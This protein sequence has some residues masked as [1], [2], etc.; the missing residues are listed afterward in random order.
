MKGSFQTIASSSL[1][2]TGTRVLLKALGAVATFL[3]LRQLSMAH[4][5]LVSLALGVSGPV[6]ALSGLG[7]DDLLLAMGA[8]ARGEK[9]F[10]AFLPLFTGFTYV[11]FTLT[12]L[13]I[14]SSFW[15][16]RW[17]TVDQQALI[18]E[19]MVPLLIWVALVALRGHLDAALQMLERFRDYAKMGVVEQVIRVS[20]VIGL[21]LMQTISVSTVIWS[22]VIAKGIST[23]FL[24]PVVREVIAPVSVKVALRAYGSYVWRHGF[25][26]AAR[27]ICARVLSGIDSWMVGWLLGLEAVG[28]F[29]FAGTLNSLLAQALPFR[30]VLVPF[31]ARLSTETT[32][33]SSVARRMAKYSVWG[34]FL[35]ILVAAVTFPWLVPLILPGY[36]KALPLFF[37]LSLSQISRGFSVSHG[38]LLYAMQEQKFLFAIS[39]INTISAFTALPLL[40]KLFGVYGA[41]LETHVSSAVILWFRERR[42]RV[43]HGLATYTWSDLLVFDAFDRKTCKRALDYVRARV[44]QRGSSV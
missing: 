24:L 5:G 23:L 39:W 9:A 16:K 4:Y 6:L 37:L 1:I 27:M 42:L 13:L 36:A 30:Q 43:K 26:E 25:W 7:L 38:S 12:A 18:E 29:S 3:V 19:F 33:S 44:L 17:F 8:R 28:L 35:T 31:M 34:G 41:V 22:Y 14:A 10:Q 21:A 11:K 15:M 32:V 20:I 2:I 40:I